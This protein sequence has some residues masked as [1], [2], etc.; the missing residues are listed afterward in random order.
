MVANSNIIDC[1][2]KLCN[3]AYE[4]IADNFKSLHHGEYFLLRTTS[5]PKRLFYELLNKERGNFYWVPLIDGPKE[6][7]VMIEKFPGF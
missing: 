2:N 3:L 5:N 1:R 6:W 4:N 7:N